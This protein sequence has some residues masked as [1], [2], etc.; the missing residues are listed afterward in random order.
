M[1]VDATYE[2]MHIRFRKKKRYVKKYVFAVS[3]SILCY[4]DLEPS[5]CL[6]I[7]VF[8]FTGCATE[9]LLLFYRFGTVASF[10]KVF[11]LYSRIVR[12]ETEKNFSKYHAFSWQNQ[13]SCESATPWCRM[14]R[15]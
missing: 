7:T 2:H 3:F 14:Y 15:F 8:L 11:L 5:I 10:A 12:V 9:R 13:P 4:L 1:I 6:I